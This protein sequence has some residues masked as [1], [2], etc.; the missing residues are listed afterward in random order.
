M[1]HESHYLRELDNDLVVNSPQTISMELPPELGAGRIL[2]TKMKHGAIISDWK[3]C[4]QS[5]MNVQ[6]SDPLIDDKKAGE[7][8][9]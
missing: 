1:T 3:M 4:Y 6:G 9:K 7:K 8:R 5:D 2:Q